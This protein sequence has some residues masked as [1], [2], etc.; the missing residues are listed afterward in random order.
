MYSI[1]HDEFLTGAPDRE[2]QCQS[3]MAYLAPCSMHGPHFLS[4]PPIKTVKAMVTT[5]PG[6]SRL[7]GCDWTES[8][9]WP[10]LNS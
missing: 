9:D 1:F 2:T 10:N 8:S 7:D 5:S 6:N 4:L 3:N